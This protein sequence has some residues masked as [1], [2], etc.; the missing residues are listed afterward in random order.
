MSSVKIIDVD[1]KNIS[2]YPA[3]CFL[4]QK[5]KGHLIKNEWL[6]DNFNKGLKIKQLLSE[7]DKKIV[8]FIEYTDGE[9]AWRAVAA[10]DH[11][12]I[13][14]LWISPNSN[15]QKGYGSLL[16]QE[17]IHDAEERK[18]A[19]VAVMTS[20]GAFMAGKALFEKNGFTSVAFEK[21]SFHLMVRT[22]H[23]GKTPSFTNT[24]E[25]LK[26]YQGLHIVYSNQ[27]PWVCRFI[28]ELDDLIKKRKL[29][30]TITQLMTA[31][32]AQNAPSLYATFSLIYNGKILADHYISQTRFEN[33][34][35][36]VS[37]IEK[38]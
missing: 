29:D 34:I 20:E 38:K 28:N 24:C 6:K 18:K 12:F 14:C 3:K 36:K 35:N 9:H 10:K 7:D 8:G 1:E 27:C 15:K 22:L 19:G 13:N 26:R 33:I 30:I 31:Q 23:A 17:V 25:Q 32:E 4:N 2:E 16:V 11:L 21:P 37:K 5:Q